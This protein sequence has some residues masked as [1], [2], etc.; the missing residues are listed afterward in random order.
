MW[1]VLVDA[2]DALLVAGHNGQFAVRKEEIGTRYTD[3]LS[4][5]RDEHELVWVLLFREKASSTVEHV[6]CDCTELTWNA[7]NITLFTASPIR[8]RFFRVRR[9]VT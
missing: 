7:T 1:V 6:W 8:S 3:S 4:V 9:E 2:D 5:F